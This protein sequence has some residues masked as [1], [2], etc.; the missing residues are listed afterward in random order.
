VPS[1]GSRP[2]AFEWRDEITSALSRLRPH[3]REAFL[4]RYIEGLEY[5]EMAE[6]TGAKEPALRMRVKRASDQ[7]RELLRDVHAR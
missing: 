7:L 2:D 1:N 5:A 3:Y 6:M 4:L